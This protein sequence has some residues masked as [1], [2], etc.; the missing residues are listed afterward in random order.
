LNAGL[1]EYSLLAN[2]CGAAGVVHL[3]ELTERM[4]EASAV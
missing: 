2:A 4:R 1:P 3:A